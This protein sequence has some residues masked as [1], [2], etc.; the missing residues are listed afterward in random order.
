MK[1]NVMVMLLCM[2][3]VVAPTMESQAIVWKVVTAAIKKVVKAID[4]QIQRQQ[5]KVIWLQNAQ[6]TLENTLSRLKLKE[7]GD[8]SDKQKKLYAGYFEE[9]RKV[10]SVISYYQRIREITKKQVQIVEQYQSA[11]RIVRQ[12]KRFTGDEITYMGRVYEGILTETVN[13]ID[14]LA[15]VINAFATSMSDAKRLEIIRQVD[16][17][18]AGNL[19]DLRRFN[20]ETALL[21]LRR[22]KDQQEIATVRAMYGL[23]E[24]PVIR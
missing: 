10:R 23:T 3:L 22:A 15:L 4:L 2:A 9:L 6:K 14:Q 8:W 18:V 24:K 17:R 12:D 7:I 19:A 11:W 16:E 13:N 1:K 20:A 5:N 21:S